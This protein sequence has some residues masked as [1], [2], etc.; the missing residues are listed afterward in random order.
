MAQD[1]MVFCE[2]KGGEFRAIAY[3]CLTAGRKLSSV[4]GGKCVAVVAGPP[5]KVDAASLA[6]YGAERVLTAEDGAFEKYAPEL[7]VQALEAAAKT[8]DPAVFL[9]GAT[10]MGKDLAPRLAAKLGV[11]LASDCT[12]LSWEEGKL[13]IK[14]PVYA[15]K[16]FVNARIHSTPGIASIR[17]K[18]FTPD[19]PDE[20]LSCEVTPI[21]VSLSTNAAKYTVK[22]LVQ[23][24]GPTVD[25][26]EADIIVSGGRG[27]KSAENFKMIEDLAEAVGGVVGASRAVVDA[28]WR[29]HSEQVG[30]T[31]K[32]VSPTLYIACGISGAIQ[33]VAGMRS[34]RV[35]VA[36]N[37]DP[38]A[39]IFKL[40]DY[41][42]VGD[43]LEVLP[44]LT[45]KIREMK[46]AD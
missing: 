5:G 46:K 27:M 23:T 2:Q 37:K 1:V 43:T 7:L 32:T 22:E 3:E 4:I 45:E 18:A 13:L 44:V 38:E 20:S 30:Q 8:V 26:T 12:G 24:G 33:H 42:I 10:M 25:L 39:P 11:S 31:G 28:D 15:G 19:E 36:V 21:E 35:I 17:P 34:S 16:A 14:R 41:G 9:F 29:P 40:A 6:G